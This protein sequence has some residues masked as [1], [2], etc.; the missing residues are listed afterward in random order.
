[1]WVLR[2]VQYLTATLS[3]STTTACSEGHYL[4]KQ[5]VMEAVVFP[6]RP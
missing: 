5:E 6:R 3:P 4:L 1:M 2:S